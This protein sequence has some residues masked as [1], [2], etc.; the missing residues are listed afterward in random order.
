MQSTRREDLVETFT[1]QAA[2]SVAVVAE[3]L[4]QPVEL[5]LAALTQVSG[6]LPQGT[7]QLPQGTW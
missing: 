2:T 6:G 5:D 4:R 1:S 7:W 3:D